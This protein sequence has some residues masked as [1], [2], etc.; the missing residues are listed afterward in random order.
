MLILLGKQ[1]PEQSDKAETATAVTLKAAAPAKLTPEDEA[2]LMKRKADLAG[3][4]A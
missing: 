3:M 2:F 4:G 1:F